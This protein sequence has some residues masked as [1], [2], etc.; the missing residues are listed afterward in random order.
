MLVPYAPDW[1]LRSLTTYVYVA[2]I[3]QER[4]PLKIGHTTDLRGRFRSHSQC[5][6]GDPMDRKDVTPLRFWPVPFAERFD[7]E[8]QALAIARKIEPKNDGQERFA[9]PRAKKILT[10]L[11][12]WTAEKG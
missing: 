12:A 11:D 7:L 9:G 4:M 1:S 5:Y 10:L 6:T 3:H 8:R 2:W